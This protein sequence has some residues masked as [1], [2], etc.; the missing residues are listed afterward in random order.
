[1]NE[2]LTIYKTYLENIK[3]SNVYYNYMKVLFDYLSIKQI[4]FETLTKEQLGEMFKEKNYSSNA[5]NNFIKA[6][7]DYCRFLKKEQNPFIEIKLLEVE[8]KLR[9]YITLD[10]IKSAVRDMA[11]NNE[12]L[13]VNKIE[14]VLYL[15]FYTVMRKGELYG[16]KR[17]DFDMEKCLLKKYAEKTKE[18]MLIPFPIKFKEKL[19][20]YFNSEKEEINAFNLKKGN[21]EY[22]FRGVISKYLE[23]K[24]SPH[25]VRHG[26]AKYLLEKGVPITVVQKMLGHSSIQTTLIYLEAD[27]KMI[28]KTYRDKIG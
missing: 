22:W 14:V 6:G 7:R 1:M 3:R 17:S 13:P 2:Q 23:K 12:L 10:D 19:I 18:E 27:Q 16:L 20:N 8:H 9:V 4:P 24:L 5:I 21:L 11:T 28:E 25:T 15:L 26:G